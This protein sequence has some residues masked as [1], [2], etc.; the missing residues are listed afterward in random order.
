MFLLD[1]NV[2]DG[3]RPMGARFAC[4]RGD[5]VARDGRTLFAA[6][7][8]LERPFSGGY[9]MCLRF[10]GHLNWVL[11]TVCWG[12]LGAMLGLC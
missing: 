9:H 2:R 5:R 12:H 1:S 6:S 4:G 3:P 10:V 11:L 8:L 7:G